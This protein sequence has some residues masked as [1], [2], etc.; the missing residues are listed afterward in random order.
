MRRIVL[1]MAEVVS[2]STSLWAG[3]VAMLAPD[4]VRFRPGPVP[5]VVITVS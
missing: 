2:A 5:L 3:G 1:V 4:K